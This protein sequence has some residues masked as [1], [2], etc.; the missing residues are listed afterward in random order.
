MDAQTCLQIFR[1]V[2]ESA[3]ATVDENGNPQNRIIDVM[4]VADGKL[5]FCTARGK[6]F[7]RE[8]TANGNVS[9]TTMNRQF[10]MVRLQGTAR[11][12][13]ESRL[14][15]DRIFEENPTMNDVYPGDSRYIL[16]PFCIDSGEIELFDLGTTPI[17]RQSF[18][19]GNGSV[20][21]KGFFIT[22]SCI[23]CD[24]CARNCPTGCIEQSSPY[25]I[26]QFQCLHCGLCHEICPVRAIIRL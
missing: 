24:K 25:V 2:K 11:R 1:E 26:G 14:W 21:K 12:M 10:Q 19:L 20:K 7:Y 15:I 17:H 9:V 3:F 18:V 4:S 13:E 8:L 5:L 6:N 23:E 22:D 16:E